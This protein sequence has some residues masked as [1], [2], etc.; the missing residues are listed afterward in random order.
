M[1][2]SRLKAYDKNRKKAIYTHIY[3][4]FVFLSLSFL[5]LFHRLIKQIRYKLKNK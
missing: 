4:L 5:L 3:F 1:M 2:K